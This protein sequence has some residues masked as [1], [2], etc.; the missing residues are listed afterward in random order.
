MDPEAV[1]IMM[2]GYSVEDLMEK[3]MS[4]GAYTCIHKP[5][6]VEKVV[7]LINCITER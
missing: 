7:T 5:F 1:V 3:A 4:E 6:D 2:T